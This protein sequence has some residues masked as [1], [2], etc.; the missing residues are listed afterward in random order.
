M[1]S[2]GQLAKEN[3]I[4]ARMLRYYDEKG[5]LMP[6][7]RDQAGIRYYADDAADKLRM[8]RSLLLFGFS[9]EEICDL[10]ARESFDPDQAKSLLEEQKQELIRK[11]NR[12]ERQIQAIEET[13]GSDPTLLQGWEDITEALCQNYVDS[14]VRNMHKDGLRT[15]TPFYRRF[16]SPILPW[17]KWLVEPVRFDPAD[18]A[19]DVKSSGEIK[20]CEVNACYIDVWKAMEDRL[21]EGELDLYYDSHVKGRFLGL[22]KDGLKVQWFPAGM[23]SDHQEEYDLVFNDHLSFYGSRLKEGLDQC[24]HVLKAGGRFYCTQPD[25][26]SR[27]TLNDW[28][29]YINPMNYYYSAGLKANR[30]FE[31]LKEYLPERYRSVKFHERFREIRMDDAETILEDLKE[32]SG[33]DKSDAAMR[34]RYLNVERQIRR[35]IQKNGYLTTKS[36]YY[37][38]EAVK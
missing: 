24:Y 36:R 13:V 10:L 34:K 16:G 14:H 33:Y 30:R 29:T 27:K 8:I 7:Y 37:L 21:P 1:L 19:S 28:A 25:P 5:L 17:T 9:V 32:K 20:M 31:F 26:D 12:L 22:E 2:I 4:S 11:K 6:V 35:T 15:D 3:G 18:N 38:I 23:L